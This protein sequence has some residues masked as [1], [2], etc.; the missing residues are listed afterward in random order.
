MSA[1][2]TRMMHLKYM[3]GGLALIVLFAKSDRMSIRS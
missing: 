1:Y 3:Q 2:N